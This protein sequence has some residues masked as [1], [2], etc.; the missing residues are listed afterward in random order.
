MIVS[1]S[2]AGWVSAAMM[3]AATVGSAS[4]LRNSAVRAK[5]GRRAWCGLVK[6]CMLNWYRVL[7]LLHKWV[8]YVGIGLLKLLQHLHSMFC[9]WELSWELVDPLKDQSSE[10][11]ALNNS[12]DLLED[13][14]SELMKNQ[15]IYKHADPLLLV[16]PLQWSELWQKGGIILIKRAAEDHI[17]RS[18]LH[19]TFKALLDNVG[20]KLQL[21]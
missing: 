14:I 9:L 19:L 15:F 8:H 5:H 4:R 16:H 13:I 18:S 12:Y 20:G 7:L 10:G 1:S 3:A 2:V 21:T 11:V 6:G 17:D